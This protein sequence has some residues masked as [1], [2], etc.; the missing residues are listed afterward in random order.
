MIAPG[1][2]AAASS[3][4][5]A[6]V[7]PKTSAT[8]NPAAPTTSPQAAPAP[9]PSPTPPPAF[10]PTAA[11]QALTDLANQ[12][13]SVTNDARLGVMGQQAASLEAQ[14]DKALATQD[15]A[16]AGVDRDLRRYGP[17]PRHQPTAA[18]AKRLAPLVAKRAALTTQIQQAQAVAAQA[19]RTFSAIAERRRESFS[20]RILER[21]PSPLTPDFWT[22]LGA[23]VADDLDRTQAMAERSFDFAARAP[24]PRGPIGLTGGIL[25]ALI[26]LWPLR[27]WMERWG[28]H[29][30][31]GAPKTR[32]ARRTLGAVW[33]ALLDFGAPTLAAVVVRTGCQWGGLV[34]TSAGALAAA[35]VVAVA[36][37]A[38]IIAL[39]RVMAT[40]REAS[41]RLITLSDGDAARIRLSL[42]SVAIVT[43]AGVVVRQL[44]YTVGASVDATIAANCVLSLAYAAAAAMILLS[45]GGR[46]HADDDDPDPASLSRSPV[47]TLISL[48]LT[49]TIV[50]TVGA[51]LTGFTTL[52]A[53]ISGQIFWL[54]VIAGATYLLL[55]LIDDLFTA[56]FADD[57]RTV[58]RISALFGLRRSAILQ[59]GLLASAA[60]QVMVLLA[61]VSLALT[62]YGQSG[63]LLLAH[64]RQLGGPI[65]IGKA[66]VSPTAIAAGLGAFAVGMGVVHLVRGWVVR[67][68]LPVT[69]WDSGVR[70][71]VSTGVGYLGV[72]ITLA[73]AFSVMGLGF[74]QIALIA[75]ALSVGIGFGLQ[76]VVQNFVAGIILLIERPVKVGDWVNVGGVEGDVRRI[77]VRAT[78]IQAFDRSMVIVPNSNLITM[79]VQNKT[80]GA[81]R[82]R[83]QLQLSIA[84]AADARKASDLILAAA[85]A[86]SDILSDPAPGVFIDALAAGGGVAFNCFF[87]VADPRAAYHVRS[88]LFFQIV[89]D[90]EGGGVALL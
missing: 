35:A 9:A 20:A 22:A 29:K 78:E 11:G 16:L 62:P 89:Q 71:S 58:H 46:A 42:W 14:A 27:R 43:G 36:W 85:K 15:A 57:G 90:F 55:R 47:W 34:S 5:P 50:M 56:L 65:H 64:V 63:E 3:A 31:A 76:Q 2:A 6:V 17:R 48:A 37:A 13:P 25:A 54:S 74:Q 45:I 80:L 12:V 84:K 69:D 7:T 49:V 59:A 30:P 10:D 53:L 4:A 26:I 81:T 51:V 75:S 32:Q 19:S 41:R 86:R 72:A 24:I 23:S 67:R 83:I 18:E 73:C 77:R 70:N 28:R 68:Y 44:N 87:Y 8:A 66:T 52:A 82:G 21:S 60:L 40:D 39:G 38:A 61:A 33:I 88:D 1:Q 79:N